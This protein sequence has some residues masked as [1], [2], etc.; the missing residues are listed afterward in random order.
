LRSALGLPGLPPWHFVQYFET[1]GWMFF[2]KA[3][4]AGADWGLAGVRRRNPKRVATSALAQRINGCL[5][6]R[7]IT[8]HASGMYIGHCRLCDGGLSGILPA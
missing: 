1:S 6:A 4:S 7:Y 5:R 2:A 8:L 3:S